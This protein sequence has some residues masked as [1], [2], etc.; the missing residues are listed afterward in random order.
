MKITEYIK[1]VNDSQLDVVEETHKAIEEIRKIND[2]YHYLN[3]ISE[4]LAIE[5]AKQVAKDPKKRLAGLMVTVKDNICVKGVESTAGSAILKGYK[6]LFNATVMENLIKEGAIV[7]GKTSQ[8]EFGFGSFNLNVGKGFFVPKNPFDKERVCGGSSGGSAGITSKVSFAHASI[9]ESTG[10]SIETPAN[11]CGVVG[12]CPTYGTVSRYGLIDYAN[13]FDKIGPM[14]KTVDEAQFLLGFMQSKDPRDSTSVGFPDKKVQV[15]TVGIDYSLIELCDKEVQKACY[16]AEE[17][18]KG[19]GIKINKIS[20]PTVKEFGISAYY[21]L[22]MSEASTNLAKYCGMRYG[23][24]S[25]IEEGFNEYFSKVRSEQFGKE[26]KRRIM[27]GTFARMAGYR[28]AFYVKAAQVRQKII[29]EYKKQ[30]NDCQAIMTPTIAIGAPKIDEVS[31]LS[32]LDH[33]RMDVMTVGPN[34]AGLPH[35]SV[36]VHGASSQPGGVMMIAD[37]FAESAMF[38]CAKRVE[39]NK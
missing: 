25:K 21:I 5:Q 19:S 32:P 17:R 36:P 3:T 6:P 18:L 16:A 10:G 7:L 28:D 4:Q 38:D 26:A 30:L 9:A 8:D 13:S 24:S 14:T 35:M 33:Y 11:F 22:A 27:L 31:K 23:A 37:H 39:N 1:K 34:L 15:K 20:L 2:E 12:V 29:L